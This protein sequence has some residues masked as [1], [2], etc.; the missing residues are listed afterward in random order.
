MK[1]HIK[2]PSINQFRS[3][4]SDVNRSYNFVGFDEDGE[5]IYD[6]T[7]VKPILEFTGTIKLHGTNAGVAYN[8]KEGMWAQSRGNIITSQKDNAGFGW[9]VEGKTNVFLKLFKQVKERE[10]LNLYDNTITIYGEWVG[11]GI[12]KGVAISNLEKSL[13]IFG[14]KITPFDES[15]P[16]YWVD[17]VYLSDRENRVY[18]IFEYTTHYLRIDFN[19][20]EKIQNTIIDLTLEVEEECPVAKMFGFSGVGEGIVWTHKSEGNHYVFKTKGEKHSSSKVKTLASVDV[21]KIGSIQEFVDYSVTD[22]RFKQGLENVF[23]NNEPLDIKKLG[24]LMKWVIG[25][26]IKEETDTLL[27]NGLEPKD[28]GRYV[29]AKVKT[30]FLNTAL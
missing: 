3:V 18:N 7:K 22:S 8:N 23:P 13:F 5:A 12:Q 28:I 25:D 4:V 11:K 24:M 15:L 20:P 19:H 29:S 10:K 17:C 9:F 14:V 1:K 16:A 21:D 26:I 27:E 2:Y 6:H 30:M